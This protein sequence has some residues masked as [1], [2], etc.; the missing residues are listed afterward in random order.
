M[1][2]TSPNQQKSRSQPTSAFPSKEERIRQTEN[3]E[4]QPQVV[5][6]LGFLMVN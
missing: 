1:E 3:E 5:V 2:E 6:A 4:P